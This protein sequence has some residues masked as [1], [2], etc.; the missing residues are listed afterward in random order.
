MRG[1]RTASLG[2]E[3]HDPKALT[4]GVLTIL[5]A[6]GLRLI[7][8]ADQVKQKMLEASYKASKVIVSP[9]R[10]TTRRVPL[11]LGSRERLQLCLC[12]GVG[13]LHTNLEQTWLGAC[14]GRDGILSQYVSAPSK[15][16]LF[17]RTPPARPI[18]NTRTGGFLGNLLVIRCG[19]P[20]LAGEGILWTIYKKSRLF[21]ALGGLGSVCQTIP[22]LI[23]QLDPITPN[24]PKSE[25]TV[26]S[27][28]GLSATQS[29]VGHAILGT[30]GPARAHPVRVSAPSRLD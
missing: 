11:A 16:A 29:Q 13:R 17:N 30:Y 21:R 2:H 28:R 1:W 9:I 15:T 20:C 14:W 24:N 5:G 4:D 8:C 10:H 6:D 3:W 7:S 12:A 18:C 23:P 19:I 25:V 22:L 27:S 26:R